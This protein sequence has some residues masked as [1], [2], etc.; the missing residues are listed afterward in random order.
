MVRAIFRL[1]LVLV[2]LGGML[3]PENSAARAVPATVFTVNSTGDGGDYSPGDGICNDG[4]GNCTLRAALE[5]ASEFT[6]SVFEVHFNI[7]GTEPFEIKPTSALPIISNV[8][9]LGPNA[10]GDFIVLDGNLAGSVSGL[11]IYSASTQI[12]ITG[13]QVRNF[14]LSGI[15]IGDSA[16]IFGGNTFP[17]N[18]IISNKEIGIEILEGSKKDVT[19]KNNLVGLD[20]Y[21][22]SRP[23]GNGIDVAQLSSDITIESNVISGNDGWGVYFKSCQNSGSEIYNNKIGMKANGTAA[24]Q[25]DL[26]GILIETSS[27]IQIGGPDGK[28]NLISGNYIYG[29]HL[30]KS[31]EITI[32][33]NLMSTNITANAVVKNFSYDIMGE[34]SFNITIGGDSEALGN[35]LLQGV[36]LNGVSGDP[37]SD[38]VIKYNKVGITGT[39]FKRTFPKPTDSS[40]GIALYSALNN[41]VQLNTVTR[42]GTGIQVTGENGGNQITQNSIYENS[43]LGIDLGSSGVTA[44]D[45]LDADSGANGLQNFPV[46]TNVLMRR[47]GDLTYF[48]LS[49]TLNSKVA[50]EYQVEIYATPMCDYDFNFYGEGRQ[51]LGF[52]TFL[53]DSVGNAT[54]SKTDI[55][56]T[57]EVSLI[58]RCFT[59][60]ATDLSTKSTSEFSNGLSAVA[61]RQFLPAAFK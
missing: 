18:V 61:Q 56:S 3:A 37:T 59:T 27:D 54:W 24:L 52:V 6:T 50:T 34:D 47:V 32:Q 13:L 25:N 33:S 36:S 42:F 41:L 43:K 22:F 9:I 53:T 10:S 35:V 51:Y 40:V 55:L 17:S 20:E 38:N 29:I 31:S 39:G 21:G 45:D 4:L 2:L 26:G 14:L 8:S 7:P 15:E 5:E 58:G 11:R 28:G 48:D 16:V 44:N 19:I 60:T 46:V 12:T 23:N 57:S 1:L 30:D 49:G